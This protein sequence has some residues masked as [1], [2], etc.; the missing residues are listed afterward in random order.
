M[1]L[2]SLL[3]LLLAWLSSSSLLHVLIMLALYTSCKLF[4]P[5]FWH[6][7]S[8]YAETGEASARAW[9]TNYYPFALCCLGPLLGTEAPVMM[10]YSV[11]FFFFLQL[12]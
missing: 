2:Q 8:L 12:R 9:C 6:R 4:R 5:T 1:L 10:P 3:Q 11:E 7:Q